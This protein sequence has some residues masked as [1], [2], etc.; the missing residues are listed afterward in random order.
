MKV[1]H[2]LIMSNYQELANRYFAEYQQSD[3]ET[4]EADLIRWNSVESTIR[5][6]PLSEKALYADY[7]TTKMCTNHPEIS[8]A[9]TRE[10]VVPML[11][12]LNE[13]GLGT[14]AIGNTAACLMLLPE[15]ER[16]PY[17]DWLGTSPWCVVL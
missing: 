10:E 1:I 14:C 17:N 6:M 3:M 2:I 15:N 13:S 11:R 12:T 16:A 5:E 4:M 7:V 9:Y 8:L